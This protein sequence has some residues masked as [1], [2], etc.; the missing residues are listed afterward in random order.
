MNWER[1]FADVINTLPA[2]L[3][4]FSVILVVGLGLFE[5]ERRH[6]SIRRFPFRGNLVLKR[7][8]PMIHQ[9]VT[10]I[11]PAYSLDEAQEIADRIGE[12]N[13]GGGFT[14]APETRL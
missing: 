13:E 1:Y 14:F 8:C 7:G 2:L 12:L 11:I 5:W 3:L 9:A 4:V 10:V 6:P